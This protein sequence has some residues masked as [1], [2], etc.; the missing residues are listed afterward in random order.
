[1][2]NPS[3]SSSLHRQR[4]KQLLIKLADEGAGFTPEIAIEL[5]KM[6]CHI[7]GGDGRGVYRVEHDPEGDRV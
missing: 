5:A 4:A 2:A 6:L 7:A 3:Q 1:M